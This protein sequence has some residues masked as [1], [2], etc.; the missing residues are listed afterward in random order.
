MT[1]STMI[2]IMGRMCSYTGQS[3]SWDKCINSQQRLGPAEYSW[4]DDV[5]AIEIAIPGETEFV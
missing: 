1:N 3:L 5:P 4:S 2:G